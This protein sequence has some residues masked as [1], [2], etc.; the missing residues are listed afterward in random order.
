MSWAGGRLV[1]VFVLRRRFACAGYGVG[2][3]TLTSWNSMRYDRAARQ[4]EERWQQQQR[5]R[6][7]Q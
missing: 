6:R 3:V 2:E 4:E 5:Q 1:T 7:R